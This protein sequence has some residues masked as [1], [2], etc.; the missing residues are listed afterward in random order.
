MTSGRSARAL[1]IGLAIWGLL[2][3]V[4]DLY[5]VVDPLAS[6]GLAA[7]NDGQIYD[8]RGPFDREVDSPAWNAGLRIGDRL[9]LEAMACLPP[10][11]AAC[12]DL[13]SVLGGMG[14][15]QL[16]RPGRVLTLMVRPAEG[17]EARSVSIAA[18]PPPR[19][20]SQS[21]VL[22]VT[23]IAGIAF[24]SAAAWLAWSRPS[25]MSWGFFLYAIWFNPGQDFVYFL[26][27]QEH[28]PLLM[29]QE[30]AASL[31]HGVACAGFLLFALCVPAGEPDPKWVNVK[32]GLP[33]LA[34]AVAGIQALSYA[35]AFGYPTES[36]SRA[37]FFA[38]YGVDAA[39][40]WILLRRRH[41]QAPQNYQRMRW[42]IWGSL[43]GLPAYILSGLLGSTAL[44]QSLSGDDSVPQNLINLL[45][46]VYGILGWFVFEAVRRPRV[47]N[48]SIPLRR[49]TA[50]GLLLSVPTLFLHQQVERL[51]E[52]L[53]LPGWAWI[54]IASLLLFLI[55]KLHEFAVELADRVFNRG[56]RRTT[57]D[58]VTLGRDV[59][60]AKSVEEIEKLLTEKPLHLLD[61]AS[62]AVFRSEEGV[63]RRHIGGAGWTAGM[64]DTID[65][66]VR[67]FA[68]LSA[69]QP[70]HIDSADAEGS[71][72][73]SGLEAPI[74]GVPVRDRLRCFAVALYGPHMSGADLTADER[75][76]LARLAEDAALAYA[77]IEVESLRKRVKALEF[78]LS[79][80]PI[81]AG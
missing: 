79:R 8:V 22:L 4:P 17:G 77:Q 29:A 2:M 52:V 51:E 20:W 7:D 34:V 21:F 24:L 9:D 37:T 23:E 66:Q 62:A 38:D 12:T 80:R 27:L 45:L 41:G 46:L 78:R 13:L 56:F 50:F 70:F 71:G 57:A 43:I 68:G 19:H 36:I 39:A 11:G 16:V 1:L 81:E 58:F 32:R 63:F 60:R 28:P 74:L 49:F 69:A 35:N 67:A 72:F 61:L 44:W 53:H 73:P 3:I 64:A 26:L 18:M 6:A 42:V 15:V 25:P 33:V 48:V 14:G 40:L 59:L 31:A 75:T 30:L 10:R 55:G 5:R 54:A 76:M 65:P 47:V